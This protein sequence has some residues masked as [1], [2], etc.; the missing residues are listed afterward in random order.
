[1]TAPNSGA[2]QFKHSATQSS[3]R[4]NK[5]VRRLHDML[6]AERNGGVI[7]WRRGLLILH[8]IDDFT[9]IVLPKYFNTRN[10]KTF[11]R[12]L[13]YYGFV[14]LRS[15]LVAESKTTAL[16]V[17]QELADHG[18]DAISSVLVLRRVEPA[19]TT[20][21]AKE[22]RERK[23]EAASSVEADGVIRN[24]FSFMPAV[25]MDTISSSTKGV[26]AIKIPPIVHC[27]YDPSPRWLRSDS[28][29]S[30]DTPS[31]MSQESGENLH[32]GGPIDF[33]NTTDYTAASMLLCLSRA[34]IWA[35]TYYHLRAIFT[36]YS[37]CCCHRTKWTRLCDG[38]DLRLLL[39][40]PHL[41]IM[42][43]VVCWFLEIYHWAWHHTRGQTE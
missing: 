31:S 42:A 28:L 6:T 11:R 25:K 36:L 32:A 41:I 15:F 20:K 2:M 12:Q 40:F 37:S 9:N 24:S 26:T 5:F 39:C 16:W 38:R 27:N 13:N 29:C 1:M 43:T 34:A 18:S 3:G 8:S 14:H 10:F 33:T 4:L 35:I 30:D 22:R 21:T 7:E 17:N 23:N 19:E